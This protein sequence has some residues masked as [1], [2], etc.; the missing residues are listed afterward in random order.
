MTTTIAGMTHGEVTIGGFTLKTLKNKRGGLVPLCDL[1]GFM[2]AIILEG[3]SLTLRRR[4]A[5]FDEKTY[6][7]IEWGATDLHGNKCGNTIY[8]PSNFS[9]GI[10]IVSDTVKTILLESR[11]Q[12]IAKIDPIFTPTT[13]PGLE[14]K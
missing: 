6:S 7:G 8:V 14:E 13:F 5:V 12:V 11:E 4:F 2:G 10:S 3:W 9:D 1:E